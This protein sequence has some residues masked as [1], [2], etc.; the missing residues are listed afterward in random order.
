MGMQVYIEELGKSGIVAE[1]RNGVLHIRM[2][3]GIRLLL[4]PNNV[5]NCNFKI[6]FL[7]FSW[8][9]DLFFFLSIGIFA[10]GEC[11]KPLFDVPVLIGVYAMCIVILLSLIN[12]KIALSRDSMIVIREVIAIKRITEKTDRTI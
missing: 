1:E 9:F 6:G 8:M 2:G 10:V 3:G 5:F 12:I 7:D 11:W 4:D